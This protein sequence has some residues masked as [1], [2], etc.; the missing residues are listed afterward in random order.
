MQSFGPNHLVVIVMILIIGL[1]L[2]FSGS[3]DVD[4]PARI[5]SDISYVIGPARP[6][7]TP[8]IGKRADD[9][10]PPITRTQNELVDIQL[11]TQELVAEIAPGVTY[12]YWTFNGTVPGPM[13]R[14]KEGDDVRITLTHGTGGMAHESIEV[15]GFETLAFA[16]SFIKT[17][18]AHADTGHNHG[19]PHMSGG[20]AGMHAMEGHASHS[21]D[22]HAVNGPGGGAMLTQVG[23]DGPKSFQFKATKPGVY[24]YHCASPHIPTHIANGMYG[25]IVVEPKEGMKPVDKE[26][27]VM[28]GEFYTKGKIGEKGHQEFSLEKLLDE[29]PTYFAFNGRTNALTGTRAMKAKVGDRVRMYIGVGSHIPSNFHIIGEVID[30]LYIDGSLSSPPIKDVQTTL[31]PAGGAIMVEF[32]VDVPGSYLLVDHSLTRA[33]DKG[34]V[35]ELV[36]EGPE[37]PAVFRGL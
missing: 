24:V 23:H 18:T 31:I 11:E 27:Y 37:N 2:I 21:I 35:A 36:V 16:E 14:V 29:S 3:G 1:G 25:L 33:I 26:F 15:S 6:V 12:T 32:E 22:L 10:L 34:A 28:Q 20:A 7:G 19:D 5:P 30:E 13:L 4:V 9:V 17:Q 8:E